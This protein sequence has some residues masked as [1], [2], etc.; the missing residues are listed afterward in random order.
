MLHV[1]L[2]Y[3]VLHAGRRI[4]IPFGRCESL[5]KTSWSCLIRSA[6]RLISNVSHV[7]SS[8]KSGIIRVLKRVVNAYVANKVECDRSICDYKYYYYYYH[9][10]CYYRYYTITASTTT[11][12]TTATTTTNTKSFPHN[13]TACVRVVS[14]RGASWRNMLTENVPTMDFFIS[15]LLSRPCGVPDVAT[16]DHDNRSIVFQHQFKKNTCMPHHLNQ[17]V[18]V[19][20]GGHQIHVYPIISTNRC[21]SC[22]AVISFAALDAPTCTKCAYSQ[23]PNDHE[24]CDA[25][26]TFEDCKGNTQ[27][28]PSAFC[29]TRMAP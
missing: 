8:D 24:T 2:G 11:T 23:S 17:S 5:K 14:Q 18:Q 13:V 15:T 4:P 9:D 20:P 22:P 21:R 3:R 29:P 27:C 1:F 6:R 16:L 25:L 28:A 10:H 26:K 19:L 7:S 12:T